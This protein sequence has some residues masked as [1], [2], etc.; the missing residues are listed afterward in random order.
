MPEQ[1][2]PTN[3]D[4]Y[5][6]YL[7]TPPRHLRFVRRLAWLTLA[8]IIALG[9]TIAANQR[10]PGPALWHTGTERAWTG[11]LL[12]DP[13][14]MLLP[15]DGTDPLL[16]VEMAKHGA[17][18][19]LAP[20]AG[21]R[22]TVRGYLLERDT[23]RMIELIPGDDAIASELGASTARAVAENGS[24]PVTL[25]GE[26]VD[27]KCYLG[28]M[29]PG[30]GIAHKSC[31]TLCIRGGLPPMLLTTEDARP[32]FRLLV[33]DGSTTLSEPLL[34]LV[35]EP[36]RIT[37]ELTTLHGLPVIRTTAAQITPR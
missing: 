12:T 14:P 25:Q 3:P 24:V 16:I 19:R 35:A 17:H 29:K 10:D 1:P 8:W 28:A 26:I 37:G 18:P 27:G 30:D 4:F 5:V 33:V 23:R 11:V 13:Y 20:F 15:D 6:G 21:R 36:V 32:V 7:P 9:T 34:A 2:A 31:A 22:I